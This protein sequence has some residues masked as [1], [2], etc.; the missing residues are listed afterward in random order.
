[1][2]HNYSCYSQECPPEDGDCGQAKFTTLFA[3]ILP[4]LGKKSFEYFEHVKKSYEKPDGT[5]VIFV[6]MHFHIIM[7][8][9]KFQGSKIELVKVSCTVGDAVEKLKER[10]FSKK[11]ETFLMH[12]LKKILS[13]DSRQNLRKSLE[14][15]EAIQYSDYSI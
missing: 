15:D 13:A 4:G 1:M 2:Y 12:S 7:Q 8:V 10:V 6:K 9:K 5:Q 3:S 11:R 14:D